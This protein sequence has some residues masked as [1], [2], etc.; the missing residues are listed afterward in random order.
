MV[1]VWS[2]CFGLVVLSCSDPAVDEP[3][4]ECTTHKQ[5]PA[6]DKPYC[7]PEIQVR[8]ASAGLSAW[9][10]GDPSSVDFEMVYNA[11][12][13][14][15]VRGFDFRKAAMRLWLTEGRLNTG[16]RPCNKLTASAETCEPGR[17]RG[18]LSPRRPT[19]A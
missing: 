3:K 13:R 10:D 7:E 11:P 19:I 18:R 8:R 5:C 9:D 1:S 16:E 12:G 15:V 17:F 2:L 6:E 14:R 4:P